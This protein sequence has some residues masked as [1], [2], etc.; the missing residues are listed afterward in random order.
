MPT[1][2]R[3]TFKQSEKN[4]HVYV[5][6]LLPLF[7]RRLHCCGALPSS[8]Q[9]GCGGKGGRGTEEEEEEEGEESPAV[10][11]PSSSSFLLPPSRVG[12]GRPSVEKQE[13]KDGEEK[14]EHFQ[15]QIYSRNAI[16]FR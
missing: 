15:N 10:F 4:A 6:V 12:E 5:C 9:C 1:R 7:Q 11:F 3:Q 2:K 16:S 14:Q 8:L 13:V